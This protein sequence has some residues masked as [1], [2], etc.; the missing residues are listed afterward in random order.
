[1][2]NQMLSTAKTFVE[3]TE[4]CPKENKPKI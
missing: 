3:R 2:T 1:M 4:G